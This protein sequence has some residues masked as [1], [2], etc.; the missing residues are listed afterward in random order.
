MR[1]SPASVRRRAALCVTAGLLVAACWAVRAA[2]GPTQAAV[3]VADF[4]AVEKMSQPRLSPSGRH[5]AVH[6]GSPGG[7]RRLAVINVEPPRQPRIVAGFDDADVGA[8][9]WVDDDRLVFSVDDHQAAF[10]DRL[11]PGLYA[12]DQDG[13]NHRTLIRRTWEFI[14]ELRATGTRELQGNHRLLQVLTDGSGDVIVGQWKFDARGEFSDIAPLRLNTR[15]GQASPVLTDAPRRAARWWFD[16]SGQPRMLQADDGGQTETHWRPAPGAPWQLVE[17]RS[18]FEPGARAV[19]DA[20]AGRDGAVYIEA[21][22]DDADTTALFRADPATGQ[23]AAQPMVSIDGF[24]FAG[25]LLFD[26]RENRLIGVRYASDARA[27]AWLS[28]DMK[29]VQARVDKKLPGLVNL[30]DPAA[31]G[32]SRWMVVTSYADRQ[33]E[34]YWLYDRDADALDLVGRARPQID[35][36]RMARR[37]FLRVRARDGL[38]IPLH[39]TRPAG[40]GPWPAVVLVHGGPHVRGGDWRWDADSQFL[41]SR[42]YLVLEPEFRGSTGYGGRL[43]RA[44]W[45]QWGLKSQDDMADAARWAVAR[46]DADPARICIAGGSYGG[47]ATLMG[48]I[49]DPDLYR[50]GLAWAAVTDIGLMYDIAWSDLPELWRRHGMPVLIGDRVRDAEQLAATSPLQQAQRLKRPLL[51]A[52]GGQDRRVPPPHGL[53]LRDALR[54]HANPPEWVAYPDEGHGFYKP[55]NLQDFWMRAERFLDRH[56]GPGAAADPAPPAASGSLR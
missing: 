35:A 46:G 18:T 29:T 25:H 54:G 4:F 10:A 44:G 28:D 26:G 48:L 53:R 6:V 41:A 16:G 42:G 20:I 21:G 23:P 30:I 32:C 27:T 8:F 40:R 43:F 49:R 31:C 13:R 50:C 19:L 56:I 34:V 9:A 3:P 38:E 12:V 36:Q 22:R 1:L 5:L 55:E 39:V 47:Y 7:R 2:D 33:P 14:G 45:K 15:S 24:D 17:R 37:D 52:I 11:G 51:L